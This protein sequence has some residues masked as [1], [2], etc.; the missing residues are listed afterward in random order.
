MRALGILLLVLFLLAVLPLGVF[1]RY[2]GGGPLV[3]IVAGPLG[4]RLLPK[5]PKRKKPK[6]EK[7]AKGKKKPAPEK[8]PSKKPAEK[9]KGGSLKDFIP[10]VQLGLK[11]LGDFRRKL[12]VNRLELRIVLAGE[13]PADLG[14]LYGRANAALGGLWPMLER[15]FKIKKRDVSV[16]CDFTAEE[17]TVYAALKITITLGRL[18]VLG[19]RYGA[20]ALKEFIKLK[21]KKKAVQS[22]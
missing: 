6:K 17:T 12:R 4:I 22:T 3:K 11:L 2:D 5:K 21:N 19:V 7:K 8:T 16:Q 10:F 15:C 9:K 14:L 13:D 18:M 1:I 20:R